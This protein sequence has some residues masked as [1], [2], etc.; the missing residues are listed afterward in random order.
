MFSLA[1][2]LDSVANKRALHHCLKPSGTRPPPSDTFFSYGE[3]AMRLFHTEYAKQWSFVLYTGEEYKLNMFFLLFIFLFFYHCWHREMLASRHWTLNKINYLWIIYSCGQDI[4]LAYAVI[5]KNKTILCS[6]KQCLWC[7]VRTFS[8]F[9]FGFIAVWRAM[10]CPHWS[11]VLDEDSRE[12]FKIQYIR[13]ARPSL[14]FSRG[15]LA[16]S[17]LFLIHI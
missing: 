14:C 7:V 4:F 16:S 12:P 10:L 5:K 15:K 17:V 11:P 3:K 1:L 9:L 2:I 8:L 13:G 6:L